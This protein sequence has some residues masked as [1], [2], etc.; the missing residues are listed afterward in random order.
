MVGF[1]RFI[2]VGEARV[3]TYLYL[4]IMLKRTGSMQRNEQLK[5]KAEG[6]GFFL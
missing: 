4:V 3:F 1:S 5:K 2:D 6:K